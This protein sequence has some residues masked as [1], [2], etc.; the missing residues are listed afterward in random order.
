MKG[1]K[2]TGKPCQM[3]S[4]A[5]AP[6]CS[7]T[8]HRG[9]RRRLIRNTPGSD[10]L[11]R[12]AS[13]ARNP[14]RQ[15]QAWDAVGGQKPWTLLL[16][17]PACVPLSYQRGDP[18]AT[19]HRLICGVTAPQIATHLRL[20]PLERELF[21][22]WRVELPQYSHQSGRGCR[23]AASFSTGCPLAPAASRYRKP[24]P[25]SSLRQNRSWAI[26]GHCNRPEGVELPL[27]RW[28]RW[29]S[30]THG[31][32]WPLEACCLLLCRAQGL[33]C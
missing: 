21:S 33:L 26:A 24:N 32:T 30:G 6:P 8:G 9:K 5:S 3:P 12:C 10:L 19:L 15:A 31:D 25:S 7:A 4:D 17:R 23:H 16:A 2:L 20:S 18:T 28:R 29:L 13:S 11:W 14:G 1:L 27:H 22:A